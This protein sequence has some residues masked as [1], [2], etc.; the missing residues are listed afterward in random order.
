M[1]IT[2]Q[3]DLESFAQRAQTASILAIDTEFLREKTYYAKLC[4]L[5]LA[6]EDEV[7]LIDPFKIR[8]LDPLLPLFQN[9][10]IVK[11]FHAA[12]QDLDIL[13]H[14]TGVLPAPI[15]DTQI[16]AALLGYTQ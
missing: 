3:V 2:S 16:A 13:Y 4:L 5:Q 15:F 11:L 1:Y 8:S 7:A 6:T 14:E 9:S 12:S 10:A